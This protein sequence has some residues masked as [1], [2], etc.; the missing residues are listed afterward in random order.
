MGPLAARAARG[1]KLLDDTFPGWA[2]RINLGR[3]KMEQRKNCILGQLFGDFF[4]GRK[5]FGFWKAFQMQKHGFFARLFSVTS[6]RVQYQRLTEAW[7][8]EVNARRAAA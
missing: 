8:A 1:A 4:I 6:T 7:T 5:Q 3:L 2:D